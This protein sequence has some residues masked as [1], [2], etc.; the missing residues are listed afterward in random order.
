M[1]K[2]NFLM[3]GGSGFIG[4]KLVP[5]L[6][7][8]GNEVTIL[9]R[10]PVKTQQLFSQHVTVIEHFDQLENS[11]RFDGVI[12]LAGQG[13]ADK[14]WTKTVKQQLRDS[15]LNTTEALV[16]FLV[17]MD[18]KPAV[19]ISGSA[20]GYYGSHGDE[21]LAED[22]ESGNSFSSQLCI[23][24]EQAASRAESL[25]IRTCYLRTGVV[26]GR[27]GGALSKMLP[28]FKFGLGGAMGKGTQWMSWIHMDDLIGIILFIIDQ[29][30]VQGAINAT[31]PNPVT[32]QSFSKTLGATL[33]RP[34]FLTMP[35]FLL[36]IMLGEM[37]EELLLTGQR[38]IPAKLVEQ[39]YAFQFPELGSALADIF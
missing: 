27:G 39:G 38:V 37:S 24:W 34:A 16:D 35:S 32:N 9:S 25:G 14:R 12:N 28:S 11:A 19:L 29:N 6:L 2:K 33:N 10:N 4:S 1:N 26:L 18:V 13:I 7:N 36:N 8:Q 3:T 30:S 23:D 21:F 22:A 17:R 20:I 5:I 15:R 31:A